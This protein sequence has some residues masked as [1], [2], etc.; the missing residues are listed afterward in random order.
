MLCACAPRDRPAALSPRG[1]SRTAS[2]QAAAKGGAAVGPVYS[3]PY[4][5][6]RQTVR[7][8]GIAG[9]YRGAAANYLRFG[10]YCI[11]V[12]VFVEQGRAASK[13][14]RAAFAS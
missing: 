13:R 1:G 11:L 10:P 2:E 8:E 12:F 6:I 9:V 7:S 14:L 5:C 4:D 3:G